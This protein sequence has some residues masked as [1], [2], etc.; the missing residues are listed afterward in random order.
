MKAL[1]ALTALIIGLSCFAAEKLSGGS[2]EKEAVPA[3]KVESIKCLYGYAFDLTVSATTEKANSKKMGAPDKDVKTFKVRLPGYMTR[4][5]PSQ[6]DKD[7]AKA[8]IEEQLKGGFTAEGTNSSGREP[9]IATADGKSLAK[10]YYEWCKA[11]AKAAKDMSAPPKE[12][13]K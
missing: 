5:E 2:K 6:Q 12:P 10:V 4:E 9:T 8:F 11:R 13:G 3:L 1:L 7:Q